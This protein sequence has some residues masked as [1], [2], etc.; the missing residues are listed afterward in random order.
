MAYQH[1][2]WI[3]NRWVPAAA[4]DAW[5]EV[6]DPASE[7]VVG[8][9]P[10]STVADVDRAVQAAKGAFP[11][12]RDLSADT[13]VDLLHEAA[14]RMRAAAAD[15]AVPLTHETGR[16]QAR[17]QYY[18]EWS[19]RVFGYYA[20]LARSERGHVVPSAEPDGQ[21][22]IVLK[23]PYGVVGCI[24]PW[25]YPMLLLAWKMAPALAAG[26]TV[27]VKPASQTPLTTLR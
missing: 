25:N 18:I 15:L 27:V 2:L 7:E 11:A 3:G 13:R 12:W 23:Q 5:M 14:R 17:N 21:L 26:N 20:E 24:V 22:N 10:A 9:V 6:V 4:P 16:M 19:A 8:R 1:T